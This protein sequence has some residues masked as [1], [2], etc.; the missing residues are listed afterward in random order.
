MDRAAHHNWNLLIGQ[1]ES[2]QRVGEQVQYFQAALGEA[3]FDYRPERVT[4]ARAM[5]TARRPEQARRDAEV[6]FRWF[7]QTGQEVSAPP[8][9]GA[10]LLPENFRA[11]RR[12]FTAAASFSYEEMTKNITLFGAPGQVAEKIERLRQSGVANLI[13]FVNYGGIE[14]QKVLDSLELFA[15]EVMPQFRD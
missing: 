15:A 1:G 5:Y 3:G 8:D 12:R 9:R 14:N 11:Y 6:P 13:L 10:E 7:K 4:V 2:F